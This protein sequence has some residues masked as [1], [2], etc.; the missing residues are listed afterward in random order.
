MGADVTSSPRFTNERI[1]DCWAEAQELIKANQR[2]TGFVDEAHFQP[3]V[4]FY[5][6]AEERGLYRLFTMR[7]DG[8]LT[9]YQVFYI[10][11]HPRYPG[12]PTALQDTLYVTPAK[13]GIA[14]AHFIRYAD[15]ELE[16]E[17]LRPIRQV[18]VKCDYSRLLEHE[19]YVLVERTYAKQVK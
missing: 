7:H 5:L 16:R 14:S 8:E 10:G 9:G 19:G 11:P 2:E 4:H 18:S 17:G 15:E 13:R 6:S 1:A 12:V 3:D